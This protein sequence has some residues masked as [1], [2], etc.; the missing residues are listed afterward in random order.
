VCIYKYI[1]SFIAPFVTGKATDFFHC[2]GNS[3]LFQI[4]IILWITERNVLPAAWT[5][6]A[7]PDLHLAIYIF[8]A[9]Q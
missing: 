9:F 6:S 3:S 8:S 5:S 2:C 1:I 7:E 4:K